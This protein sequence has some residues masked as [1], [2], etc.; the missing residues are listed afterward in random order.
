MP[1]EVEFPR[2]FDQ[3]PARLSLFTEVGAV[4]VVEQLTEVVRD[5]YALP[6]L[7]LIDEEP[8]RNLGLID[9]VERI[10]HVLEAQPHCL[11]AQAVGIQVA[12]VEGAAGVEE[13]AVLERALLVV[14]AQMF[15]DTCGE[16]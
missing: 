12:G 10:D 16:R 8:L 6:R 14:G 5:A 13:L 2:R 1:R 4:S 11:H 15:G 3:S 9:D 7:P